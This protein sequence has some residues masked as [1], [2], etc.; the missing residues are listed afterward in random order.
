MAMLDR[1]L[2]RRDKEAGP[3]EQRAERNS[4]GAGRRRALMLCAAALPLLV[5]LYALLLW[6]ST[7]HSRGHQV[8]LDQFTELLN[9]G[10]IHDATFVEPDNRIVGTSVS[11]RYWLDTGGRE[12]VISRL[13]GALGDA[14]VPTKFQQQPLK[15]L[16]QPVTLLF[17]ALVIVDGFFLLFLLFGKGSDSFMAFGRL[18]GRRR[19]TGESKI[20]FSDV[21]GVDEAIE[22]LQEVRDYLAD[23]GRFLVMG[24][25]VPKG[26]LLTGPP[27]CGKTLLAR[28]LA[29]ESEVPFFSIAGSDF[30][31]LFVGIGA[32]RIR[33]FFGVAKL[34]APC[35]VFIDELDAVG[36][37]RSVAGMGGADERE[38]TLNQLLVEMDGF[39][40][41]SGVV[42]LA[43]TNRPDILDTALLRPGRFDRRVMVDPPD[44]RGREGILA[45][46][47]RGKPLADDVDLAAMARRTTGFSGADLA[48]VINEAALLAARRRSE[49]IEASHCQE[50]IERA[51]AGPER[52]SRLLSPQDRHRIA[53][54]EAGHALVS[55]VLPSTE[56]VN[57]LSLVARG[58]AGGPT[59]WIPHNDRFLATEEELSDRLAAILAGQA[60]EQLVT[61]SR[62]S[63][64]SSDL[65]A[66]VRLARRMICE[67]GMGHQLGPF[68]AAPYILGTLHDGPGTG[69]SERLASQIDAE[70]QALLTA[71]EDRA[72]QT[73]AGRRGLLDALAQ[74]LLVAE[75]LE[76]KE[77]EQLLADPAD[78]AAPPVGSAPTAAGVTD[79]VARL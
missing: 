45:I 7:P 71:A 6:W 22:E 35:I 43:A 42:V 18:R 3:G 33:D 30:A 69:Y 63:A 10:Q 47:A 2:R 12:T 77:L 78:P 65:D 11:G 40:S 66:A 34:A 32:A 58:H 51:V 23:P 37:S 50:A 25:T 19:W 4:E 8:R 64:A 46:H 29:G 21:A 20:T 9:R 56:P 14:N 70:V 44:L 27:G 24:A 16:V 67:F 26:I 62:S 39:D 54:H 61:G 48:N 49:R 36:R 41:G 79:T 52:R 75:T 72:T 55:S 17:P 15:G 31:E 59:W 74:A 57:K 5:A 38:A 1:M 53:Y 13:L 73:L 28:A 68:S 60:A 76:G